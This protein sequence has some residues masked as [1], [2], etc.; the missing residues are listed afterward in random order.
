MREH[1][2]ARHVEDDERS[3]SSSPTLAVVAINGFNRLNIAFR[4]EG[5]DYKPGM[6]EHLLKKE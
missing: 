5:G 2:E 4:M 1:D 3:A 6:F